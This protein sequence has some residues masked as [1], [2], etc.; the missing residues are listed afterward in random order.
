MHALHLHAA[1]SKPPAHDL[2]AA[3]Q[4]TAAAAEEL[5]KDATAAACNVAAA[6]ASSALRLVHAGLE[7][8]KLNSHQQDPTRTRSTAA[9]STAAAAA[10]QLLLLIS[11]SS[12]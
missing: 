11:C 10:A 8:M 12:Y 7:T 2:L 4:G 3:V 1:A 6:P 9:M 5:D